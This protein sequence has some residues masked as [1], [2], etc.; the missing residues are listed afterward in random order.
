M[1]LLEPPQEFLNLL[2]D[3]LPDSVSDAEADKCNSGSEDILAYVAF[4]A[5]GLCNAQ[6]FNPTTWKDV[7]KPYLDTVAGCNEDTVETFR[8]AAAKVAMGEDDADSYGEHDDDDQEV[9]NLRF[10]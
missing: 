7:L 6:E 10:K 5:V 9:C 8:E 2:R 1:S 3:S 4:L